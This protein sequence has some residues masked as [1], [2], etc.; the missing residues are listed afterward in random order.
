MKL[1]SLMYKWQ[2]MAAG[3]A[4]V[5]LVAAGAWALYASIPRGPLPTTFFEC[6]HQY[7][8]AGTFPRTCHVP[9]G[10]TFV[11]YVGNQPLVGNQVQVDLPPAAILGTS[12]ITVTGRAAENWYD[13][14]GRLTIELVANTGE[15]AATVSAQEKNDPGLPQGALKPFTVTITFTSPKAGTPGALVVHK[16]G[17]SDVLVLPVSF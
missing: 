2:Y 1:R 17:S 7:A 11:E 3:V 10:K 5:V 6:S 4:V 14:S 13:K 8:V 15:V 12:P 9:F 16:S